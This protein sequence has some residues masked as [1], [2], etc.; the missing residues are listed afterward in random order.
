MGFTPLEG[1][2]MGTR[3]GDID[4]AI[5]LYM[6]KKLSISAPEMDSMLNKKSGLL[7]ITGKYID[8]RDVLASKE[9]RCKLAIEI[10]CYRIKKYIG[11]YA[12]AL[13]GLDAIAFTAGVGENSP[14]M[15]A[16]SLEGLSFLGIEL[17]E[18]RNRLG[19]GEREISK[20]GSKVKV[21]VI[22]TDEE[23]VIVEDTLAIVEGRFGKDF[24]YSFEV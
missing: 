8:R 7:G 3:C 13:G 21:Y 19:K 17:D 20:E 11:A 1:A 16:K 5:P 22:P 9:E 14:E 23:R 18:E 15:R 2:V 4:A 24:K 12:C 6:M 10:E